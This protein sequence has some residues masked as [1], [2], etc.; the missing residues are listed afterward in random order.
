MA[1]HTSE[2]VQCYLVRD[3]MK[4][5]FAVSGDSEN[6]LIVKFFQNN[7]DFRYLSINDIY[8]S[9]EINFLIIKKD[10]TRKYLLKILKN[11]KKNNT[12]LVVHNSLKEFIPPTYK[13]LYYPIN[14]SFFE[15]VVKKYKQKNILFLNIILSQDNFLINSINKK[16]IY[17]T[18]KEYEIIKLFFKEKIVMKTRIHKEIF[19]LQANI[20]TKS[21]DAHLSRIRNKFTR[22]DS[23]LVITP[24]NSEFLEI[25]KLI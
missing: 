24:K 14:I 5:N 17:I 11:I 15:G 18:E 21:L 1:L 25:K 7:N 10:I 12:Q 8:V 16:K 2:L 4:I 23:G 19:N 22:I 13:T 9:E 3:A 6:E 20:D